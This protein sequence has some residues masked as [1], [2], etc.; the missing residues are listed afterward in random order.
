MKEFYKIFFAIILILL[1]AVSLCFWNRD[2]IRYKFKMISVYHAVHRQEMGWPD[3]VI[4]KL[5]KVESLW[6]NKE[7]FAE[8]LI[9]EGNG[10]L[11]AEGLI[12]AVRID[13]PNVERIL[14]KHLSDDRWNWGFMSND[15]LSKGLLW[16]LRDKYKL[17]KGCEPWVL[18][19]GCP[20]SEKN[21]TPKCQEFRDRY[22]K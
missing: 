13:H 7:Q 3:F 11:V 5:N 18:D 6:K 21:P 2:F 17:Q 19:W 15:D 10:S 20:E 4:E 9:S 12:M 8:F 22:K 1:L 16:L 14:V